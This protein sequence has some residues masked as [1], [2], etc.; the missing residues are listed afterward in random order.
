MA[1]PK[2]TETEVIRAIETILSDKKSYPTSL[3][4]AVDYCR[5]GL[6]YTGHDLSMQIPYILNNITHWRHPEAKHVR[7]VLKNFKA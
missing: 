4:W 1:K 6:T 3:N 5:R 7:E 2:S